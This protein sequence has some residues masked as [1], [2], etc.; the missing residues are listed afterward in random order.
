MTEAPLLWG[1]LLQRITCPGGAG[2]SGPLQ[3]LRETPG[4][5]PPCLRRERTHKDHALEALLAW[6]L[7]TCRSHSGVTLRTR[8]RKPAATGPSWAAG[9]GLG[10]LLSNFG[11]AQHLDTSKCQITPFPPGH[12]SRLQCLLE[13]LAWQRVLRT[14]MSCHGLSV[15]KTACNTLKELLPESE[16]RASDVHTAGAQA[17]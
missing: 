15:W 1:C 17:A 8:G 14:H 12:L 10:A 16:D 5:G 13:R 6:V 2:G 11:R 3:D 9:T 4:A 7:L